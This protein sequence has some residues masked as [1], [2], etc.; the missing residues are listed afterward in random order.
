MQTAPL[1]QATAPSSLREIKQHKLLLL[2]EKQRRLARRKFWTYFPDTGPLARHLYKKHL[3]FFELGAKYKT[4]G[5]I[6]GNRV[7]KTEGGGGFEVVCH[8]TGLYPEWWTGHRFERPNHWWVAGDTNETVRDITQA[9]LCGTKEDMGTGLIPG[10]LLGKA[11]YRPNSNG[12]MDM[13][14]VKHVSGGWSTI[15]F[16]SYEQGRKAFQGTEKDGIWLDEESNEGVRAECV[17]RLM[18]TG[19]LLL[20]TFTPLN[21]ITPIISKYFEDGLDLDESGI[22]V[23]NDRAVVMAGWDDVPHLSADDKTRMLSECEPHLR[24]A[25][26]K[27]IPSMGSGA[28]YPIKEEDIL[29]EPFPIPAHW[30]RGYALDVGWNKTAC[31]WGAWDRDTDTVYLVQEH[32]RGQAEPAIH[33]SAI[34]SR[35]TYM[36]GVI[37]PAARGRSQMDGTKL[38][39]MYK[40]EGL[41]LHLAENAVEAGL[42]E[43]WQRLSTGRLKVFT[44]MSNFRSEY[45]MYRRDE[46]GK[47][48]KK[49]DHLMDTMRYLIMSKFKHFKPFISSEINVEVSTHHRAHDPGV[50]Y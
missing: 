9:K 2:K 40:K 21:G 19:G 6:A 25:R 20:E 10:D 8:V 5:F 23:K 36:E 44:S 47:I 42:Y 39:D 22:L 4:R 12:A 26:S 14:Y 46:H 27:G 29:V 35:G 31:I 50:G 7:G 32:Y 30:P 34:K 24:D 11:M 13:I 15:G 45:R 43:V 16:K 37:D 18:T 17:M 1:P 3:K 49:N 41:K 48:V 28:I 33:A 38:I